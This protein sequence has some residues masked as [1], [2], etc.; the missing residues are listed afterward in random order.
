MPTLFEI[1][2]GTP[3]L[4]ENERSELFHYT[5]ADGL[6]GILTDRAL[7]ATDAT[8]LNDASEFRY[9]DELVRE[10]LRGL[11]VDST[12]TLDL[13]GFLFSDFLLDSMA[14]HVACFCEDGDLL[15]QWRAYGRDGM[16]YAIGFDVRKLRTSNGGDA[17]P[18]LGR[19]VYQRNDQM[20]IIERLLKE[21]LQPLIG[22]DVIIHHAEMAVRAVMASATPEGIGRVI[23]ETTAQFDNRLTETLRRPL[24]EA[25]RGLLAVRAFLK[26][27]AFS[28][29]SEWRLVSMERLD[30]PD[31]LFRT[32][33]GML[34][35]RVR[36]EFGDSFPITSI[37]V[38]P[39]LHPI[40]AARSVRRLLDW[41]GWEGIEVTS[42]PIPLRA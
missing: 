15:S 12:G 2:R 14:C 30:N 16:G 31:L 20:S 38:G 5:T 21:T 37:R 8:Y 22:N 3:I 29:E 26:F 7:W 40:E 18:Y 39:S 10:A 9:A 34:V 28:E 23:E 24:V 36:F 25:V 19:V 1:L 17:M 33:R 27:P 32:S 11:N 41:H 13:K 4:P 35:P 42:S 6:L